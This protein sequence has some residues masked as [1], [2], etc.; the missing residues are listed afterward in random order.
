M[1][2]CHEGL[3]R[4][5]K[6]YE[7][8]VKHVLPALK[9][10]RKVFAY[11][12][13]IDFEKIAEILEMPVDEIVNLL[14]PLKAEEVT[15]I[16]KIA[17]KNSLVVIDEVHKFWPNVR[18]KMEQEIL[19]WIAEHGHDG[20][21]II[22]MTQSYD[23]STHREWR[24]RTQRKIQFLKL[25]VLGKDKK[26]QWTAYTG[27]LSAKGQVT[28]NKVYNGFGEYDEKYFGI[29]KSHTADDVMTDN[30]GDGRFNALN[31]KMLKWGVPLILLAGLGCG[32]YTYHVFHSPDTL[33]TQKKKEP[34]K[35]FVTGQPISQDTKQDDAKSQVSNKEIEVLNKKLEKLQ[36]RL[37]FYESD[38][39]MQFKPRTV[40]HPE[41]APAY[42]NIRNVTAMPIK[43]GCYMATNVKTSCKCV[44]QQGTPIEG[45]PLDNCLKEVAGNMEFNP[46]TDDKLVGKTATADVAE[47]LKTGTPQTVSQ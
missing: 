19:N 30:Y 14:R 39:M 4:S 17:E 11:I 32:W 41:T 10:G 18:N 13:G 6:S 44:T 25:D 43:A 46:Y 38:P 47:T 45:Y 21:D 7:A 12:D 9:K 5:G 37:D 22:I 35:D 34:K 33:V 36:K 31:Q 20:I 29:Y 15:S 26:Y 28:W 2:I 24:N 16:H 23:S 1:I 40:G 42:D 27:I 3:P 8:M